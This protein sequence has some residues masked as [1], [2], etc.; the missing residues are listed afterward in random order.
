MSYCLSRVVVVIYLQK[1]KMDIK[2]ERF[3]LTASKDI[4]CLNVSVKQS[5]LSTLSTR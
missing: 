1:M 3:P 4:I 2:G 5:L